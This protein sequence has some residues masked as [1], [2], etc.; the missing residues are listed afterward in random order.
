MF[1]LFRRKKLSAVEKIWQIE[2]KD[3]FS[4]E[5]WIYLCKKCGYDDDIS[6]LSS[7]ER[8]FYVVNTVS[9]EVNGG[10]FY[11]FFYD[12]GAYANEAAECMRIIGADATA[13]I[14]ERALAAV[15]GA[16]PKNKEEREAVLDSLP[17]GVDEILGECDDEF[18]DYADN[19]AELSYAF[20]M[21]NKESFT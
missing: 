7:N 6:A 3:N 8:V 10:G 9:A 16:L 18:Y 20:A 13:K 15:G 19:L 5:L 4:S 14:C 12:S 1:G 17:D 2:D 11:Q 21:K